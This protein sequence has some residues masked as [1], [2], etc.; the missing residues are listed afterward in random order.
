MKKRKLD[1][2]DDAEG[3]KYSKRRKTGVVA[4]PG[5]AN[6]LPIPC[7]E[8]TAAL[9]VTAVTGASAS[10]VTE[11]K[12]SKE[13]KTQRR[14]GPTGSVLKK[15]TR[16]LDDGGHSSPKRLKSKALADTGAVAHGKTPPA[17]EL[18]AVVQGMTR[19]GASAK[20]T[21]TI[22]DDDN[23]EVMHPQRNR[24]TRSSK[25]PRFGR[26]AALALSPSPSKPRASKV[27]A[28]KA[29]AAKATS[30]NASASKTIAPEITATE[31]IA[32]SSKAPAV[33]DT[34]AKSTASKAS[35]PKASVPKAS[36]PKDTAPKDIALKDTKSKASVPKDTGPK[37]TAL[38]NTKSKA[39]V[40]KASATKAPAVKDT[41]A[42][43][44]ASKASVPKA[45]AP[46]ATAV[47]SKATAPKGTASKVTLPDG[48]AAEDTTPKE[49]SSK[50]SMPKA[51]VPKSSIRKASA[52]ASKATASAAD[53]FTAALLDR[54]VT[55]DT[56]SNRNSDPPN[57]DRLPSSGEGS[58]ANGQLAMQPALPGR[59][60]QL[61]AA[62][63]PKGVR[64]TKAKT[65]VSA[66]R[67]SGY[68]LRSGRKSVTEE[69]QESKKNIEVKDEE[70][71]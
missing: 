19:K 58:S 22:D 57:G 55:E 3:N 20:E 42:K 24:R 60:A 5:P 4:N 52:S 48:V 34:A 2:L 14:R 61:R 49:T 69:D 37:D 40:P 33:K 62:A 10:G 63:K 65:A 12:A 64:K 53:A 27:K 71:L 6:Y 56:A 21:V 26:P 30:T 41:A 39:A 43:N 70:E 23:D 51:S 13:A 1:D 45:S 50:A 15:R 7:S 66:P 8:E 9:Q 25:Q 46:R 28:P 17:K 44:T 16:E 31:A 54:V 47:A 59:V 35:V 29:S 68:N 18:G 38:K 32:T 67:R 11:P 36:V